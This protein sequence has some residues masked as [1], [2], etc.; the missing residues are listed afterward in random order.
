[1]KLSWSEGESK[2]QDWAEWRSI[3]G[4]LCSGRSWKA[5]KKKKKKTS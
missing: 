2:A 1:M 4:G 5:K 3:V